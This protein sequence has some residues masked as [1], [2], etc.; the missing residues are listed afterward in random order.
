MAEL[1]SKLKK[2]RRV[3]PTS[4]LLKKHPETRSRASLPS[5]QDLL[6]IPID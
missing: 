6:T 5:F 1:T 4:M 2:P 3:R